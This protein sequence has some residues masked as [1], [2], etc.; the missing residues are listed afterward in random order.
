V[1]SGILLEQREWVVAAFERQ[2]L[3][4]TSERSAGEWCLLEFE[5]EKP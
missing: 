4:L 5:G 2:G 3:C 1:L